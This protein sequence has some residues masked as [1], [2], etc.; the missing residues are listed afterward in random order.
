VGLARGAFFEKRYP[1]AK[2][3]E[4][5]KLLSRKIESE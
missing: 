3:E 2:L 1:Q 5:L 4:D